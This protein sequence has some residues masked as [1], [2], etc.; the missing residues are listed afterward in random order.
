MLITSRRSAFQKPIDSRAQTRR[1]D[2]VL[3]IHI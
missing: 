1:Y 2:T 3:N